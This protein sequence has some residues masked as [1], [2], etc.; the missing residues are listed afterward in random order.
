M[1]GQDM[2]AIGGSAGA[3]ESLTEVLKSLPPGLAA[4]V[5][6]VIH[7]SPIVQ[8]TCRRSWSGAANFLLAS[9]P[10]AKPLNMAT[11]MS[12]RPTITWS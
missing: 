8:V 3:L 12:P 7:T 10:R 9:L 6:V 11:S 2:I 5:F 4:A 1:A